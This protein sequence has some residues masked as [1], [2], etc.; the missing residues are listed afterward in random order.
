VAPSSTG[1]TGTGIYIDNDGITGL[2]S[3]DELIG[4]V[5]NI[6]LTGAVTNTTPGFIWV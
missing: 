1:L 3:Q 2:S 5:Q 4:V 6:S